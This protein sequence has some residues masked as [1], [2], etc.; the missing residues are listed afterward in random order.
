MKTQKTISARDTKHTKKNKNQ[1][2]NKTINKTIIDVLTLVKDYYK[3]QN[4][5]FRI[6]TYERAIYQI[7]KWNKPI[8]KGS[9]LSEVEGI[10]K[11]MIEKIDTIISS[12]TLPI[13][14]EKNILQ[15]DSKNNVQTIL[16]FSSKFIN[17]IKN[18]YNARTIN[19]FRKSIGDGSKL[20]HIQQLGLKYYEDLHN[21]IPRGEITYLGNKLKK[22]ISGIDKNIYTVMLSGSYPSHTKEYSKD[23]DIIIVRNKDSGN[24]GDFGNA[25]ELTTIINQIKKDNELELEIISLGDTKFMGLILSPQSHKMRHIDVRFVNIDEL[26]YTWLYYSSGQI[27]N[28]LIRDKL[29]KKGYK[30]NEYGLFNSKNN[31]KIRIDVD[32]DIDIDTDAYI[33]IHKKEKNLLDKLLDYIEK[34]ERKV[35]KF[36]DMEYKNVRERY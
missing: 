33:N 7:R 20:T 35:F 6:K 9:E 12:G 23:I 28:K 36:A 25:R 2:V 30:L 18:K 21:L 17:E 13:I 26:P 32:A 34:V 22:I 10:G 14:K 1:S 11:G 3:E 31:Q 27:F 29:K 5:K 19:D 16:G 15:I 8:T 4:D 24:S